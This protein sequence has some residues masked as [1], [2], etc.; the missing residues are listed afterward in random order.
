MDRVGQ[1]R[2]ATSV[3]WSL[4]CLDAQCAVG[5]LVADA[6]CT[7]STG[8]RRSEF[9]VGLVPS[10]WLG[11]GLDVGPLSWEALS[12]V[13]PAYSLVELRITAGDL[14]SL[15]ENSM[16]RA[17]STCGEPSVAAGWQVSGL[18][19]ERLCGA[20]ADSRQ[21][22]RLRSRTNGSMIRVALDTPVGVV[23]L[24]PA[25]PLLPTPLAMPVPSPLLAQRVLADYIRSRSPLNFSSPHARL[26]T[27]A[28]G[29]SACDAPL[30]KTFTSALATTFSSPT[31]PG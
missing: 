1:A 3:P 12:S 25:L 6:L 7:W 18:Q 29:Q 13:L 22:L 27:R 11:S 21:G 24:A 5:S 16:E 9:L 28:C 15:L 19:F 8:E 20:T 23:T 10:R 30:I 17:W 31:T 4:S 26:V 14:T 2:L